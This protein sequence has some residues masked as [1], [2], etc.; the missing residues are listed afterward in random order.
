MKT[1]VQLYSVRTN[2]A[3]DFETTLKSV[4]E[5]GYDGVEFAGLCGMDPKCI[6]E[7]C[8]KYPLYE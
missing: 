8:K 6:A 7:L 5:M 3:E 2:L 4:S 1:G